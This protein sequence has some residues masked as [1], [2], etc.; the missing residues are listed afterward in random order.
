[1]IYIYYGS[2]SGNATSIAHILKDL[3]EQYELDIHIDC[4][5]NLNT[6]NI[7]N[8]KSDIVII[9]CST[10]GNGDPPENARLFWSKVKNRKLDKSWF[11]NV[12]YCVLGLGDSNYSHYCA[13]GK[14]INNRLKELGG[15]ETFELVCIDD[16]ASM[17]EHTDLWLSNIV[18]KLTENT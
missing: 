10:H 9:I 12:K 8:L 17:E 1:M 2:Q 4:L 13:M 14:K 7:S 15:T 3:L 11:L 18:T 6:E 16:N 5:N